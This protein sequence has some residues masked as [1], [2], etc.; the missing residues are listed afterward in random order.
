MVRPPPKIGEPTTGTR[1]AMSPH[2]DM[3]SIFVPAGFTEDKHLPV[4]VELMARPFED[5][6]LIELAY[7]FEQGTD[8]REPPDGFG[9]LPN[10]PPENP[11]PGFSVPIGAEGCQ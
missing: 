4:A 9:P 11:I 8:H 6:L 5:P 7:A 2:A 3:P 10:E 1:R